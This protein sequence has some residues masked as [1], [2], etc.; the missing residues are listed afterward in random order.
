M[1]IPQKWSERK[2]RGNQMTKEEFKKL[3]EDQ[4]LTGFEVSASGKPT[5]GVRV[6]V[7]GSALEIMAGVTYLVSHVSKLMREKAPE[8][9]AIYSLGVLHALMGVSDEEETDDAEESADVPVQP[10]GMP[11]QEE[12]DKLM[13]KMFGGGYRPCGK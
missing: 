8:A 9:Y 11:D 5:G 10:K 2:K 12:F 7:N 1:I 6:T 3:I 4:S 13:D